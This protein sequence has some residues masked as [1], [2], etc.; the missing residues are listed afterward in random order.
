MSKNFQ[1]VTINDGNLGTD[2]VLADKKIVIIVFQILAILH[3]ADDDAKQL[4]V[5]L[6]EL[7]GLNA[8]DQADPHAL[9]VHFHGDETAHEG[10]YT[11]LC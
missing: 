5:L 8:I 11:R 6:I 2:M 10:T 7:V 3:E 1:T 4:V 9:L